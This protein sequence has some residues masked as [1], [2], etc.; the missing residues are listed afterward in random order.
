[1][2]PQTSTSSLQDDSRQA[3]SLIASYNFRKGAHAANTIFRQEPT[4][5]MAAFGFMLVA[6]TTAYIRKDLSSP[7]IL[8]PDHPTVLTAL[9][10]AFTDAKTNLIAPQKEVHSMVNRSDATWHRALSNDELWADSLLGSVSG[11]A[12]ACTSASTRA[13]TSSARLAVPYPPPSTRS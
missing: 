3:V 5:S 10:A 9:P 2:A 12:R 7:S 11:A 13:P 8:L 6:L 1:M 4:A